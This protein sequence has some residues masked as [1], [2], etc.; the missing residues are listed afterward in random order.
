MLIN[1]SSSQQSLHQLTRIRH[2]EPQRDRRI[3]CLE[4]SYSLLGCGTTSEFIPFTLQALSNACAYRIP[5]RRGIH[6]Q[7][8]N[9]INQ[10]NHFGQ[11][12]VRCLRHLETRASSHMRY[13]GGLSSRRVPLFSL[14]PQFIS[15]MNIEGQ[16]RSV[17]FLI[18][19]LLAGVLSGCAAGGVS[20][21][22]VGDHK[23]KDRRHD[24]T[25]NID[26]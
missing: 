11:L 14:R 25:N 24:R 3:T 9:G 20:I 23:R 12:E 26:S 17:L 21:L 10:G 4:T 16:G 1:T 19:V 7:S 18:I 13:G 15:V 5:M 6:R 2:R 8:L 22:Y